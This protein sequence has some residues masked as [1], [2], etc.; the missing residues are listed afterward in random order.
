MGCVV[1][2]L[3]GQ[4]FGRE[5]ELEVVE[6]LGRKVTGEISR[7]LWLVLCHRC[8]TTFESTNQNLKHRLTCGERSC[9]HYYHL[10]RKKL[11]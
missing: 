3:K 8:S 5:G 9:R 2:D 7:A 1:K 11:I 4:R 10:K 6:L